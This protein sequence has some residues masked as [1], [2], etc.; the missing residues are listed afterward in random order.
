MHKIKQKLLIGFLTAALAVSA[1]SGVVWSEADDTA[2][3]STAADEVAEAE[4]ASDAAEDTADGSEAEAEEEEEKPLTEEE[5]LALMKLY[6]EN[7]NLA[8]YVNEET[9]VF[10]VKNKNSGYIWWSTPHDVDFDPIAQGAQIRTMN[11]A[12][13]YRVGDILNNTGTDGKSYDAVTKKSV[14][15]KEIENGVKFTYTFAKHSLVIPV[16]VTLSEDS[17]EVRM[18]TDKIVENSLDEEQL[19]YVL[20]TADLVTTLGA[21]RSDEDGYIFVPDGSGAVI[22]FNNGK[23]SA[24]V[25][26]AK[27]YGDDLAIS[28]DE[29]PDKTEQIYLPV[30]GIVKNGD[31]GSNALCAVI[32]SGD[33]Y[34][35]INATAAGQATT[36]YNRVWASF[37]IRAIDSYVIGTKKPLEVYE[38]GG[39]KVEDLAVRYYVMNDDKI[40]LTDLADTYRNYLINEKGLTKKTQAGQNEFYLSLLGGAVKAQSVLGF[41]VDMCTVGTTYEQAIEI[42]KLLEEQGVKDINVVFNDYSDGG[43]VGQISTGA[44]YSGALGG[45]GGFKNLLNYADSKTNYTVFPSIDIMEYSA[46]GKGYSFTLNSSKRITKEYATQCAYWLNY[47]HPN[48]ATRSSWTILSPY[49]WPDVFRKII[50]SYKAEG[51]SAISLNQATSVLYS[52]YSRMNFDDTE[53]FVRHD[54]RDILVDGYKA[55]TDAGIELHAQECNAYALPYVSSITNVPLYSS[56]YDVFDYDVPFYQMVVQGY[57]P[58]SSKPLNASA[59]E[60][61]LLLLSMLT[62]SNAHYEMMYSDPNDFTACEYEQYF[63]TYY[64]GWIE[65]AGKNYKM[66]EE[67]FPTIGD[68]TITKYERLSA[69]NFRTEFSDGTT[70]EV[71]TNNDTFKVNDKAYSLADFELKGEE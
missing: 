2:T 25:Y 5:A 21:G 56:N 36:S 31:K 33:A 14:N 71:D 22:N 61:E 57:V 18:D 60:N 20:L 13:L 59:N 70:I 19:Q 51:I 39:I 23:T 69:T 63:Y 41:P 58:Y 66:F 62:G 7:K 44:D 8:L 64:K 53:Y 28:E 47:G 30:F 55:I 6:A 35:N 10:A 24:A 29:M 12:F 27:V 4:D 1:G 43:I 42:I 9:M 34:A 32:T 49:Y 65:D 26:K 54:A 3:L 40:E 48:Y 45:A 38:S 52:D 50:E 17:F 68:K 46:S 11:S 16:T 67:F 15:V 37:D